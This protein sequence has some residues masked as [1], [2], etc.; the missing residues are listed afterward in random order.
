MARKGRP[1][2]PG[3]KRHPNGKRVHEPSIVK[4]SDWVQAQQ[5]KYQ[6]FYNSALGRAYAG[7]LL[8]DEATALDRYQGAKRFA[9]IYNRVIGGETYRCPLDRTPRGSVGEIEGS[10]HEQRDHDWLFAAMRSLDDAGCR[11]WL[12]QLLTKAHTDH[13]PAWLDRLL[14]GGKDPADQMLL[15]AAIQA[16][17]VVAPAR[18][19]AGIRTA[20]WEQAA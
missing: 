15:K 12:D 17:D 20:H 6:T 16:L 4:G 5:A 11:P 2:K 8:G 10:E 13:G 7:H 14:D 19:D 3:G 1:R 9:R 18:K